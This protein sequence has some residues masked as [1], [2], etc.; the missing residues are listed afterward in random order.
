MTDTLAILNPMMNLQWSKIE[1]NILTNPKYKLFAEEKHHY[2]K[3]GMIRLAKDTTIKALGRYLYDNGMKLLEFARPVKYQERSN[4]K[5]S[6]TYEYRTERQGSLYE[7]KTET[8]HFESKGHFD[9]YPVKDYPHVIPLEILEKIPNNLATK[10]MILSEPIKILP[11]YEINEIRKPKPIP[12]PYL[13]LKIE[14][15]TEFVL[16]C[17]NQELISDKISNLDYKYEERVT[18]TGYKLNRC[19]ALLEWK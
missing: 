13:V 7:Y 9:V 4:S 11:Q 10:T 6:D 12:D 3:L 15:L 5:L 8:N 1:S 17:R 16:H 14:P 19:V 2:D 18:P